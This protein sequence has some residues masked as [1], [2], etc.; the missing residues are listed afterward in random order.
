VVYRELRARVPSEDAS[1]KV[2]SNARRW[3][4]NS[5]MVIHIAFPVRYFDELGIPRLAA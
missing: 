3:W 2:A 5:G 4:K 1:A